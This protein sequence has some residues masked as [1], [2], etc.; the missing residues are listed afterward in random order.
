MNLAK[1]PWI[2][3]HFAADFQNH[4]HG[5]V[6]FSLSQSHL[7]YKFMQIQNFKF[8]LSF[9]FNIVLL[10][11]CKHW[12]ISF[13]KSESSLFSFWWRGKPGLMGRQSIAGGEVNSFSL[14]PWALWEFTFWFPF[15]A[16][17]IWFSCKVTAIVES[18]FMLSVLLKSKLFLFSPVLFSP[19]LKANKQTHLHKLAVAWKPVQLC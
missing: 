4:D 2:L 6:S 12:A 14:S 18:K 17:N 11:S 13:L 3:F 5:I 16:I 9:N 19:T 15:R 7:F 8:K 10:L 1:K